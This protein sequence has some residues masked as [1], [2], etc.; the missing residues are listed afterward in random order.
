M[1]AAAGAVSLSASAQQDA[2]PTPVSL[3][4]AAVRERPTAARLIGRDSELRAME[5]FLRQGLVGGAARTV[6]GTAGSGKSELLE[7]GVEAAAGAGLR[8]LRCAGVRG[9]DPG[10]RSGLLQLMWPLLDGPL[11]ACDPGP[12]RDLEELLLDSAPGAVTAPLPFLVLGALESAAAEQPLLLAVDDFDALDAASATVLAFVARRTAGRPLA[13]LIAA[14]PDPGRRTLLTGLPELPLGPLSLAHS[15]ELLALRRPGCDPLAERELL[16]TAAGNPLALLEL[17]ARTAES[18]P[19]LPP[20]SD[21]LAAALAPGA[22]LLPAG[23]R[24]LLLV[25]ALHPDGELPLLMSAAAR[26]GGT[27][28]GYEAV[29]QAEREGLLVCEGTGLRFTH[30]ATAGA[31]VH[32]VGPARCR[33][34]HAALAEVLERDPVR[35]AW[36][37]A[38]AAEGTEAGLAARLEAVHGDALER[39]EPLTAVRMLRRAA[40]L[41]PAPEDQGRCALLAARLAHDLGSRRMAR[42]LARRALRHPLGPLGTLCARL[43]AGQNAGDG[44]ERR[45]LTDPADWPAPDGSREMEHALELARLTA[46]GIAGDVRRSEA[47]LAFLDHMPGQAADP[48]LVHAMAIVGGT[49]RAGTV[50]ARLPA[51]ADTHLLPVHDLERLG[52]AALLA[53]AALRALDLYRQAEHRCRSRGLDDRLPQLWL[54]QGVAHLLMGDW[55]QAGR[56]FTRGDGPAPHR[57]QKQLTSAA[58]LLRRLVRALQTGTVPS[59]D[60]AEL[61]AAR[62][63]VRFIDDVVAVAT[64]WARVEGGDFA[65]GHAG[66]LALLTDP[67]RTAVPRYALVPFAEAADAVGTGPQARALL[68]RLTAETEADRTSPMAAELAVAGAVLSCEQD[69]DDRYGQAFA[70][71]LSRRPFLAASLRLAHG[72]LLRRRREV[73]DS[74]VTLRQ[75]TAAFTVADAQARVARITAELRAGGA[76]TETVTSGEARPASVRD[77]LSAQELRIAQLAA[78]GLSNRAIGEELGLAPR[79]IGAYLYRIFPRLGV[80]ART[81]LVAVLRELRDD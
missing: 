53:G 59:V 49:R 52:E 64:A 73:T 19:D 69:A 51:T 3:S 47:L 65:E 9:A 20:S 6:Y 67:G 21:R 50:V 7:A 37:S 30:P 40:D 11:P 26:I 77:L 48:R 43:L 74:R 38:Q 68:N 5:M 62:L 34:A 16:A 36:H 29:E 76:R 2:V 35:R 22:A 4:V 13:V 81:Q 14:R 78:R 31:A 23:T 63:S 58:S 39:G 28:P 75:A 1:N 42:M 17:P 18:V 41:Y 72:R 45:S 46:P 71:D 12:L 32:G 8:V 61:A 10:P 79:T 57:G 15:A 56:S 60:T 55:G 25:T 33:A 24:D 66:L 44:D 70:M 54:R 80:T 27:A